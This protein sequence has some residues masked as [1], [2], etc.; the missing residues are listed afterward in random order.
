MS[1]PRD[2]VVFRG[3]RGIGPKAAAAAH[4]S[5]SSPG[6]ATRGHS[7]GADTLSGP[8][9]EAVGVHPALGIHGS[10]PPEG[11]PHGDVDCHDG[12]PYLATHTDD[13]RSRD[14]GG[15]REYFPSV[16][17]SGEARDVQRE[18]SPAVQ[19]PKDRE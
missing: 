11:I 1:R 4:A 19:H 18:G 14:I 2:G 16:Q 5:E 15:P 9:P 6:T 8:V 10:A 3:V 17:S 13:E 7:A 12:R